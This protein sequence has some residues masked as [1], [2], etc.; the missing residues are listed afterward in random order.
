MNDLTMQVQKANAKSNK[1]SNMNEYVVGFES[2][3]MGDV[4]R[5]GGK[6]ASLGEM[7]SNLAAAGVGVPGGFATTSSAFRDFLSHD[8]LGDR[9][10][11]LLSRLDVDDVNALVEAGRTIRNWIIETPFPVPLENAITACYEEL[12]KDGEIAVAI[13]SS[14]TAEDLPDASFAGQQD[15]STCAAKRTSSKR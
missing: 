9:I 13:R 10:N 6:N 8:H 15:T 12:C 7:I 14:A 11:G 4:M 5:V 1:G 2:L 3:G